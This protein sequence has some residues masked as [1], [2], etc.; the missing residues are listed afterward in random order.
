MTTVDDG[1]SLAGNEFVD[2]PIRPEQR[3][4][5]AVLT[6]AVHDATQAN[7]W[8]TSQRLPTG[9]CTAEEREMAREFLLGVDAMTLEMWCDQ[10]GITVEM[11]TAQARRLQATG[12]RR[13]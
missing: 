3:L 13:T 7:W 6:S 8:F 9:W 1:A 4:A 11:V 12:W 10:A 2:R 5:M